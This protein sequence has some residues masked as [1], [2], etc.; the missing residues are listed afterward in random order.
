MTRHI[1]N[2]LTLVNLFSG[3]IGV[4]ACS[5]NNFKI[6]PICIVISLVADFLDGM[7]ARALNVK[8]ELGGQ[9]DSLADMVSFGVL[10]GTMWVQLI[11]M[12]NMSGGGSYQLHPISYLGYIF[13]VFA[14][15]RLAKFNIDTR[16]SENFLGLATPAATIFV[17]GIYL[18]FFEQNFATLP[19]FTFKIIYQTLTLLTLVGVLSFL[20][21]SEIPMFSL[22]GN[23]SKWQGN[24]VK[25]IFILLSII[26]LVI[27]R[28][29]GLSIVIV[30]YILA[31]YID[32]LLKKWKTVRAE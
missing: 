31:S 2:S 18:F 20:M 5:T 1:P 32:N 16:Q 7:A 29:I 27:L 26:A 21:V 15:L 6:V 8:S 23:F 14:C 13:S 11:G 3:C 12:S 30:L 22:K 19:T 24:Q 28:E 9:L 25:I 4:Y 17:L 10:P